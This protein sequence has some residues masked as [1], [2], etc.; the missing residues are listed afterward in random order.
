MR[1]E[2][3]LPTTTV[4]TSL[5]M[6]GIAISREPMNHGKHLWIEGS[7]G[8]RKVLK[9]KDKDKEGALSVVQDFE[10][11][12]KRQATKTLRAAFPTCWRSSE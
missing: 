7:K 2:G 8:S 10:H 6:G 11:D 5:G 1:A 12:P 3:P 9:G 4:S